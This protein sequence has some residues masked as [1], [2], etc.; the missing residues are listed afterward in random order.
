MLRP[1]VVKHF[2][3]TATSKLE[4]RG[5]QIV[6]TQAFEEGEYYCGSAVAVSR[7]RAR[8][9]GRRDERRGANA[10]SW[11]PARDRSSSACRARRASFPRRRSPTRPSHSSTRRP[12]GPA[13]KSSTACSPPTPRGGATSGA[14][15]F[16]WLHSDDGVA[17]TIQQ[18]YS[19]YLYLMASTSR[20][21]YPTKFNGMLWITG[22]DQ[23]QWGAQYWGANQSC[24][25]NAPAADQS[26]RSCST[27]CSTCT[28]ACSTRARWPP[29]SSG[30]ARAFSCPRRTPST[31]WPSCPTT[32]PPR[33]A[34][35]T[36]SANR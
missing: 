11:S 4:T 30:A 17:D 18:H 15:A 20:G 19:Y 35:C 26:A 36:W 29:S 16:V 34:T 1:P 25:Y 2:D 7:H 22:G 8:G 5:E 31:G 32:S 14:A 28:R 13:A 3:H 9:E 24:I 23:R 27:R 6:L 12:R 21:K 33:C 10:Q